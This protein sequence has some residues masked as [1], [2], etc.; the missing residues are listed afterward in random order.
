MS[1]YISHPVFSVCVDGPLDGRLFAP[2]TTGKHLPEAFIHDGD[3]SGYYVKLQQDVHPDG[4]ECAVHYHWVEVGSEFDRLLQPMIESA[5][6][7]SF[8]GSPSAGW[9]ADPENA[10]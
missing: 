3:R 1:G 9:V 7:R 5:T 8:L 10:S 4:T 2:P 6:R